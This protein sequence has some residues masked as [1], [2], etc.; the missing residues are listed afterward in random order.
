VQG[1]RRGLRGRPLDEESGFGNWGVLWVI[2][3]RR[4]VSSRVPAVHGEMEIHRSGADLRAPLH[5]VFRCGDTISNPLHE[6]V[7]AA[8]CLRAIQVLPNIP[9][10]GAAWL[11]ERSRSRSMPDS[12][13][14]AHSSPAMSDQCAVSLFVARPR[15]RSA[16]R[17]A[18]NG[19]DV[20]CKPPS[21]LRSRLR[22][23]ERTTI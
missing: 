7:S 6:L 13:S 2:P 5:S 18:P 22:F 15:Q 20:C 21:R 12:I 17:L 1:R 23:L 9:L 16:A 10:P 14:F 3:H 11:E 8:T 19:S 4:A